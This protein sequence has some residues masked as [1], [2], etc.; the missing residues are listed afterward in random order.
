MWPAGGKH[1]NTKETPT[2]SIIDSDG[3]IEKKITLEF[4]NLKDENNNT[5]DEDDK[6]SNFVTIFL[7]CFFGT[8]I[9]LIIIFFVVRAIKRNC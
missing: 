5:T 1:K 3:T 4:G 2:F 8:I 6:D 9:L 7:I